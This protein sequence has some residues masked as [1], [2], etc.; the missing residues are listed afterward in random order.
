MK[1][2]TDLPEVPR[3]E[4]RG[5]QVGLFLLDLVNNL[6][7]ASPASAKGA[8]V[9]AIDRQGNERV[10]EECGSKREAS[11]AAERLRMQLVEEGARAWAQER[12]LPGSYW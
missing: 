4:V 11:Q 10:I 8:R 3:I 12:G 9:V 5:L 1:D 7:G 6:F 2:R